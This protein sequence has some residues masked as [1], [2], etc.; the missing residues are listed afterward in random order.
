MDG[1]TQN[2]DQWHIRHNRR[3]PRRTLESP[4]QK[5]CDNLVIILLSFLSWQQTRGQ[6]WQLVRFITWKSSRRMQMQSWGECRG[7]IWISR[8]VAP[9]IKTSS[10][11]YYPWCQVTPVGQGVTHSGVPLYG[12]TDDEVDG[13]A[14]RDPDQG[15]SNKLR[16]VHVHIWTSD[17]DNTCTADS[18][19]RGITE[20][21]TEDRNSQSCSELRPE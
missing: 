1:L 13:A 9:W 7:A 18:A 10:C 5:I 4:S 11:D 15:S 12:H 14:E 19:G 8:H 17:S 3:S 21:A 2:K 6:E 16:Y 20:A